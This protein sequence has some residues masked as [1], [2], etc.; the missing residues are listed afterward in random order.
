MADTLY[1]LEEAAAGERCPPAII[2][3]FTAFVRPGEMPRLIRQADEGGVDRLLALFEGCAAG[4]VE[5]VNEY[6]PN[7]SPSFLRVME[8]LSLGRRAVL[9]A[10]QNQ[11]SGAEKWAACAAAKWD[12]KTPA[13]SVEVAG[14]Q[15]VYREGGRGRLTGA[16]FVSLALERLGK[17]HGL[18]VGPLRDLLAPTRWCR[19][20][21]KEIPL[22]FYLEGGAT[23]RVMRLRLEAL[24]HGLGEQYAHPL[25]MD[26]HPIGQ[27]FLDT[28]DLAW[29]WALR[30]ARADGCPWLKDGRL[31]I[32]VRWDISGAVDERGVALPL[33][34]PSA[35]GA[36][37]VAFYRLLRG[38]APLTDH[39]ISACLGKE[40]FAKLECGD[41][42][43]VQGVFSKAQA[44]RDQRV[45]YLL[46]HPDNVKSA[47]D[48]GW[49]EDCVLGIKTMDGLLEQVS[50]NRNRNATL[51]TGAS[52]LARRIG[53][54]YAEYVGNDTTPVP[55]GGRGEEIQALDDWLTTKG[56]DSRRLVVAPMGLGKSAL[57]ARWAER[58]QDRDDT[59][60]RVVYIPVSNRFGTNKVED[61]LATLAYHLKDA[62]DTPITG[63]TA[64]DEVGNVLEAL[65]DSQEGPRVL[66]IL[67]GVDEALGELVGP[68]MFIRRHSRLRVVLAARSLDPKGIDWLET[69]KWNEGE[70][71]VLKALTDSGIQEALASMGCPL[72]ELAL[73]DDLIHELHRLTGGDPLQLKLRIQGMWEMRDRAGWMGHEELIT[74]LRNQKPG[75]P[76]IFAEFWTDQ[77]KI[78]KQNNA[79]QYENHRTLAL[80]LLDVLAVAY[81]PLSLEELNHLTL[82]SNKDAAIRDRLAELH[83]FVVRNAEGQYSLGHPRFRDFILDEGEKGRLSVKEK[84]D[85]GKRFVKWGVKA[86][87]ALNADDLWQCE[88]RR[89]RGELAPQVAGRRKPG[90]VPAYLVKYLGQHLDDVKAKPEHYR[91]L[92]TQGWYE[93]WRNVERGGSDI[94]FLADV[95]RSLAAFRAG[96]ERAANEG[97]PLP[98]LAEELYC[99]LI[100]CTLESRDGQIPLELLRELVLAK[101]WSGENAIQFVRRL[102]EDRRMEALFTLVG[103]LQEEWLGEVERM[104]RE[105]AVTH[106]DRVL[107]LLLAIAD[108]VKGEYR[109]R[110]IDEIDRQAD[111]PLP[112][113][114]SDD[115]LLAVLRFFP[116]ESQNARIDRIRSQSLQD[117]KRAKNAS[118]LSPDDALEAAGDISDPYLRAVTL[119]GVATRMEQGDGR[120]AVVREAQTIAVC[121]NDRSMKSKALTYVAKCML[122]ACA[123]ALVA[124]IDGP[125][126][127]F[128]VLMEAA[129]RMDTGPEQGA[130]FQKAVEAVSQIDGFAFRSQAP[131]DAASRLTPRVSLQFAPFV[132]DTALRFIV[133]VETAARMDSGE[134]RDE[135]IEA[136]KSTLPTIRDPIRR[137]EVLEQA[138]KVL[139]HGTFPSES[140]HPGKGPGRVSSYVRPMNLEE[141][142]S[143]ADC[144]GD[145][146]RE[147]RIQGE[148]A[149]RRS[150][151]DAVALAQRIGDLAIKARAFVEAAGR[152]AAGEKRDEAL[153]AAVSAAEGIMESG[154]KARILTEAGRMEV[155]PRRG[156]TLTAAVSAAEIIGDLDRNERTVMQA[157][158]RI[159]PETAVALAGG[160]GDRSIQSW[161]LTEATGRMNP[162]VAVSAAKR[163]SDPY[164]QSRILTEAAGRMEVGERRDEVLAAV[165]SAAELIPYSDRQSHRA[166]LSWRMTYEADLAPGRHIGDG[167]YDPKQIQAEAVR[168]MTPEAAV[169]AAE[170]ISDPE[171][172][173]R[174]L[175]EAAG[176]MDAGQ[177]RDR[178]LAEAVSAT[179][180]I[181]DSQRKAEILAEA[182]KR[183]SPENAATLAGRIGIF[184]IKA[185]MLVEAAGRMD[186]GE[187]RDE[188]LAAGV[189]AAEGISIP[190]TKAWILVEA[191]GRMEAGEMRDETFSDAVLAAEGI[192]DFSSQMQFLAAAAGR[193]SPENAV[194]LA[195][196]IDNS[197][198]KERILAE[199]AERMSPDAAV[200]VAEGIKDPDTKARILTAAAG[201]MNAGGPRDDAIAATVS[202]ARDIDDL[203]IKARILVE[204]AGRMDAGQSRDETL[205]EAVSAAEGIGD[206]DRKG[207]ILAAAAKRMTPES[208]VTIAD[209]ITD[210]NT[211][212][213]ILA[214]AAGRM[215]PENAAALAGRIDNPGIKVRALTEA[216]GRMGAGLDRDKTLADAVS[217]SELVPYSGGQSLLAEAAER[218]PLET[219]AALAG[220]IDDSRIKERILAMA[221]KRMTPEAAVSVADGITDSHRKAEVLAEAAKRMGAGPQREVTL[222]KV[223]HAAQRI[224]DLEHRSRSIIEAV[225][226][227]TRPLQRFAVDAARS[228][229][230]LIADSFHD[231]KPLLDH[232]NVFDWLRLLAPEGSVECYAHAI[233]DV[234]R[235]WP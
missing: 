28:I 93:A 25:D 217:T 128:A 92:L 235:R 226:G 119:V 22:L 163:I 227:M 1:L 56:D 47:R 220:H 160:I 152:M 18:R 219:A 204:A 77:E 21:H 141:R 39:A 46:L 147:A 210:L 157:A 55:F 133:Q 118:L 120:D 61:V 208:A 70:V 12:D 90:E 223:I 65:A 53:N 84:R 85:L 188:V 165:V 195:G 38:W 146:G 2:Q 94:G 72:D 109:R 14:G 169:T 198:I 184:G 98:F 59:T 23:G 37:L 137:S 145:P 58:I 34:G 48:A 143:R 126:L 202:A 32:D 194:T 76:G 29:E 54:F 108:K 107:H 192:D 225:D 110:L 123:V 99:A 222:M 180:G 196:Y 190:E 78:W 158:R 216:A 231:R 214:E 52:V 26:G 134:L 182:A 228:V 62:V 8:A 7:P 5:A 114:P 185:G 122:P 73:R 30:L 193:L 232:D 4:L 212:A 116:L 124:D 162:E 60:L 105:L 181:S 199:A 167:T 49:Q 69:L 136:A 209:N 16:E 178:I 15:S 203:T 89:I 91:E 36:L 82:G 140:P 35:G 150:P 207:Q 183:M 45:R 201:R 153:A 106:R 112:D 13:T 19:R 131:V 17:Q 234:G 200:S 9:L 127:K 102:H 144:L 186:G 97:G 42:E 175:V 81:G 33:E 172:K 74:H 211:K 130:T 233:L 111:R 161:I 215:S 221:A 155:E 224:Q 148:E 83:R 103:C 125:A 75:L 6:A 149:G 197:H 66:V 189:A 174:A 68:A 43:S 41:L 57:L 115:V 3:A 20:L 142:I 71:I 87:R 63:Q 11:Y 27:C 205:A 31:A 173:V 164:L 176:R 79:F 51:L 139:P 135:A 229:I 88:Q 177:R 171:T 96:D 191:A 129:G 86:C 206:S 132:R 50:Y 24:E 67:D 101:K 100:R 44:A 138:E 154:T 40:G 187:K 121:I 168:R 166:E 218:M 10:E 159:P 213:E 113:R 179:D 117:D 156:E 170:G 151:E 95:R 230:A 80:E 104:G 64:R